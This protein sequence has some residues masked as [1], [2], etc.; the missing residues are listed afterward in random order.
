[1]VVAD[2]EEPRAITLLKVPR[3]VVPVVKAGYVVAV[4]VELTILRQQVLAGMVDMAE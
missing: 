1:M 3:V 4:A 2:R